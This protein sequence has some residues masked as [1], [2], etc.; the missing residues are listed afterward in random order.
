MSAHYAH[1]LGEQE[2][3][4]LADLLEPH[5][6]RTEVERLRAA[7][8][9][10]HDWAALGGEHGEEPHVHIMRVAARV[11]DDPEYD[12]TEYDPKRDPAT[13]SNDG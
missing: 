2:N 4:P 11:L 5:K 1:E 3:D 10:I 9:L 13:E 6:P 12:P 8:A 7:L